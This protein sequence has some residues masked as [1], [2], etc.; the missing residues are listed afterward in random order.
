MPSTPRL[1]LPAPGMAQKCVPAASKCFSLE[2]EWL[3]LDTDEAEALLDKAEAAAGAGFVQRYAD[4]SGSTVL[5]VT[6]WKLAASKT[7]KPL[8]KPAPE[9]PAEKKA[10]DT[11]DLYFRSGR[12]KTKPRKRSP[13][14]DPRQLDLFSAP[15]QTGYEHRDPD[16]PGIVIADEEGD[17]TAFGLAPKPV[18]KPKP[19]PKAKARSKTKAKPKRKTKA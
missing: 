16:N 13:K 18:K 11:D 15:D 19:K 10:D 9:K 7:G 3:T 8:E 1:K 4:A 2:T 17:G 14:I 6:Y 5:A 12:T